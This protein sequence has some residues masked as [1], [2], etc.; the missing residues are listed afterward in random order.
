MSKTIRQI[1]DELGVSKQAVK[2]RIS[3]KPLC[4]SIQ[5]YIS[6][7]HGVKYIDDDGQ[8]LIKLAFSENDKNLSIDMGIDKNNDVHTTCIPDISGQK[9]LYDILK[10]ELEAK[11]KQIE[12]LQEELAEER[13]YIR[14]QSDKMAILADQAQKLQL[15][16][17]KP[18][19]LLDGNTPKEPQE[20]L[21]KKQN[22]FSK[23][24]GS[25]N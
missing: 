4:T 14:E 3:R 16:Q 2:K 7:V 18:E 6:T 10:I 13:K 24:F 21:K 19:N 11:N 25:K 12:K 22:I 15:A 17:M 9:E 23:I 5:P 8:N 1:A 20:S